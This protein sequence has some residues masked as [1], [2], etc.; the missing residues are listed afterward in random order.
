MDVVH[1]DEYDY[2]PYPAF[3][4]CVQVGARRWQI[5]GLEGLLPLVYSLKAVKR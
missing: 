3:N 5:K 2:S 4:G 1:F